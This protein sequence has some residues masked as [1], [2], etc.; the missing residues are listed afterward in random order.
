VPVAILFWTDGTGFLLLL[1]A[2]PK[3]Y[4]MGAVLLGRINVFLDVL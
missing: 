1:D 3:I 2:L 4:Q